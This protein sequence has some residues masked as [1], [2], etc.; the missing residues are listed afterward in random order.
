MVYNLT[1]DQG[2]LI[3]DEAFARTRK[4]MEGYP[5]VKF[6]PEEYQ[7]FYE[8]VYLLCVQ[9][10][11]SENARILYERYKNG[12]EESINSLVLPSLEDKNGAALLTELML[13]WSNYQVMARWLS[14]FFDYLDR[15]Y[16]PR[17]GT[18]GLSQQAIK[19]FDG[20]VNARLKPKFIAAAILLINQDRNGE[21]VDRSLLKNVVEYFD[22]ARSVGGTCYYDFQMALFADSSA[23]YSQIASNGLLY[24]TCDGY[25]YKVEWC[26]TQENERTSY[27]LDQS[28]KRNLLEV[29][30]SHLLDQVLP[31]LAE[32]NQAEHYGKSTDYQDMLSKC[33][34][35]NIGDRPSGSGVEDCLANLMLDRT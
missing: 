27:Y 25:M 11:S 10:T 22:V 26:L 24:D 20:L 31:K 16:I 5:G 8:C 9:K 2:M 4:I 14:R 13:K 30:R 18:F 7:R 6:T 12:L 21:K 3:L 33:A 23:Y 19:C 17:V 34:G 1:T 29:L 28:T 35:L 32:K 15:F